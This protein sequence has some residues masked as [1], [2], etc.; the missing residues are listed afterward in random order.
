[1]ST[2]RAWGGTGAVAAIVLLAACSGRGDAAIGSRVAQP[3]GAGRAVADRAPEPSPPSPTTSRAPVSPQQPSRSRGDRPRATP[4]ARPHPA[5]AV[6]QP[7]APAVI[8][9]PG[10]DAPNPMLLTAG[11]RYY[12]YTSQ[13]N[14][15]TPNVSVRVSRDL[16][17]W[18]GPPVDAMP[19]T[20][21]WAAVGFT[22]APDVHEIGGRYVMYVTSALKD[23]TPLTQCIGTAVGSRPEG[24]FV[25]LPKPLVCQLD[26]NGAID[27]RVFVDRDD[28]LWLHWK[29]DDNADVDGTSHSSIYAQ[30]LSGDGLRL[31]GGRTRIL[32]ADQ[33]WEGRIVEAPDMELVDGR[34]WLFYSGN[35]FNQPYYGIGVAECEGPAGPC[36]K[37][38]GGPWLS[39]NAQGEGPG[40]ASLFTDRDG[41]TWILYSPWAQAYT[42]PTPRPVAMARVTF[43][44]DG[45]RLAAVP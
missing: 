25:P 1:M 14:F 6:S 18:D 22:W 5:T 19:V 27:P 15:W 8:L 16:R 29:S 43:G 4:P 45:P 32:E 39:S 9:T 40:E 20:L 30:R 41:T 33:P 42:T 36:R 17:R 28:Q 24:P 13:T 35:W 44:R 12:L 26:R 3:A 2:T 11:G 37:P 34:Y 7:P 21:P 10:A 38:F 31:V 23:R